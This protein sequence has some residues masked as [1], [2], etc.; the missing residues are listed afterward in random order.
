ML[1]FDH[2]KRLI[3]I[4]RYNSAG[5][6]TGGGDILP[7][8]ELIELIIGGIAD[9]DLD[10]RLVPVNTG[11]IL[12]HIGGDH[13]VYKTYPEDPYICLAM[14]F[15]VNGPPLRQLPHFTVWGDLQELR[16]FS[17]EILRAFHDD[18][19]DREL[20]CRYVYSTLAF[21]AFD[22]SHRRWDS[23]I[24]RS[25]GKVLHYITENFS[26]DLLL[27]D[28]A[29]IGGMS[30]PY[31][32]ALFKEHLGISP[33]QHL[34]EFRL[35]QARNLLAGSDELIKTVAADCGFQNVETFGRS[36]R[37]YMGMTP[38][39]YRRKHLPPFPFV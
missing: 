5:H 27:E 10:Y 32:H 39:E 20:L 37:K 14:Q 6:N 23:G 17:D 22:Y 26:E 21:R 30:V 25:L 16:D 19:Y 36:F 3:Q 29:R 38:G 11:V 31:L 13:T 8:R 7:G 12:W 34:V 4:N 35:Q 24:P 2:V 9:F 15:E 18:E 1:R 28:L 33:H